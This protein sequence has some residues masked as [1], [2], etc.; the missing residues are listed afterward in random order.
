M[1]QTTDVGDSKQVLAK[2][3]YV[4]SFA[5]ASSAN[6]NKVLHIVP[7]GAISEMSLIPRAY[8]WR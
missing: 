6:D 2:G 5:L 4:T 8:F 7:Q 3:S 1:G